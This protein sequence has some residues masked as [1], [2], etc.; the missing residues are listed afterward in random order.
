[1]TLLGGMDAQDGG[2]RRVDDGGGQHG[3]EHTTVRDRE[4]A[5]GEFF[6]SQ[7]AVTSAG[8]EVGDLLFDVGDGHLISVTQNGYD[9]ATRAAYSD[10]DIEVAVIDDVLAVD[11][12]VHDRVLLQGCHGSLH[13]EG[14][15]AQLDAVF[16]LERI[17]VRFAQVH[18]GLHVDLVERGQNGV[19]LLRLQ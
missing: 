1:R 18:D 8:T 11:R 17:L 13:E 2:L 14:H 16:L 9:Q 19:F 6:Q 3:A 7:L 4:R 10:T 15:E 12:S 5:A